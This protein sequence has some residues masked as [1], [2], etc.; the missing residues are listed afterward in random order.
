MGVRV[1]SGKMEKPDSG[2]GGSLLIPPWHRWRA[3]SSK[4]ELTPLCR[5]RLIKFL[6]W[7]VFNLK[8]ITFITSPLLCRLIAVLLRQ[9]FTPDYSDEGVG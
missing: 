5:S 7:H 1:R 6:V 4:Q 2:F 9:K 8:T 3:A